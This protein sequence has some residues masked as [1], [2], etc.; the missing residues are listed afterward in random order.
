M[1]EEYWER[2]AG[3]HRQLC[4]LSQ[5]F[6]D[7]TIMIAGKPCGDMNVTLLAQT[8]SEIR[9]NVDAELLRATEELEEASE[10]DFYESV[11]DHLD[12]MTPG[13]IRQDKI[14]FM[15]FAEEVYR[16]DWRKVMA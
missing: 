1:T 4:I 11:Y 15:D 7:D 12:R 5:R 13:V 8:V 6:L 16:L 14:D 9:K 2:R 10:P 3:Y